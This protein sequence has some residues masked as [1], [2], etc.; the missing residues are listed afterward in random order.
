MNQCIHRNRLACKVGL[1][2]EFSFS[3]TG[4]PTNAKETS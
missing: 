1:N 3:K 4:F 2:L